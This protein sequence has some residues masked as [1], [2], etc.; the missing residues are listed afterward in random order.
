MLK[1]LVMLCVAMMTMSA[2]IRVRCRSELRR[3]NPRISQG[4]GR[5]CNDHRRTHE[6]Q[7]VRNADD[8]ATRVK[9]IG[10]QLGRESGSGVGP[11]ING[12][13]T[14]PT[15]AKAAAK[16]AATPSAAT[17]PTETKAALRGQHTRRPRPQLPATA[18]PAAP[19]PT[20]RARRRRSPSKNRPSRRSLDAAA[21]HPRLL[22]AATAAT[23]CGHSPP[24]QPA[25][26]GRRVGRQRRRRRKRRRARPRR[27]RRLPLSGA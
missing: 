27:Q 18:A 21:A 19:G 22:A 12:S 24:P 7:A 1:K 16:P 4:I 3:S 11:T 8:P 10:W 9:G 15:G 17:K 2:G 25:R 26:A 14:P 20:L 13:S 6:E 23:T 5:A